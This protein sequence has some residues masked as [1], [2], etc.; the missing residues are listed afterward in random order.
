MSLENCQQLSF[1]CQQI[2]SQLL[3]LRSVL[4]QEHELLQ[5][6]DMERLEELS[7]YKH[8]VSQQIEATERQRAQLVEN[9][10]QPYNRQSME[11]MVEQASQSVPE[12]KQHWDNGMALAR[13]CAKLNQL[14]GLIVESSK[15][16]I[17]SR[18]SILRG[19]PEGNPSYTNQG[20]RTSTL[21]TSRS[22]AQ[23]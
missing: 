2:N 3:E 12:L 10:G 16:N 17:E 4:E 15:H 7:Q 22:I 11:T 14:N 18:L 8:Q 23:A 9:Q 20:K 21:Q 19:Q 6:R 5:S 13:D 1:L